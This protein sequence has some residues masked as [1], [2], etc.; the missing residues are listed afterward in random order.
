ML[1]MAVVEFVHGAVKA[2]VLLDEF[3]FAGAF[4]VGECIEFGLE[5]GGAGLAFCISEA[6]LTG[7]GKSYG[8]L[9]G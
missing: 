9:D 1:A 3:D 4:V 7:E 6:V 5:G 2:L 8:C